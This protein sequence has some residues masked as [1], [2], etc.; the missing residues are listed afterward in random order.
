MEDAFD[1]LRHLSQAMPHD[2]AMP[3]LTVRPDYF[4]PWKLRE[5]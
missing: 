2:K 5:Q 3:C 4:G 1:N